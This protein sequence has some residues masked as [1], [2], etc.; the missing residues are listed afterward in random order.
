[1]LFPLSLESARKYR[2]NKQKQDKILEIILTE[3]CPEA[4]LKSVTYK[5]ISEVRNKYNALDS[6]VDERNYILDYLKDNTSESTTAFHVKGKPICKKAWVTI[7]GINFRRFDRID[8]DFRTGSELYVHGNSGLKRPTTKTS[9]CMAWLRFLVNAV[10]DHQP[11]TAKIHLPSCFTKVLLYKKMCEELNS[12]YHV[13][14]SQFYNIMDKEFGHVSIPKVCDIQMIGNRM[15]SK[16]SAKL[17]L[18]HSR[19]RRSPPVC[20]KFLGDVQCVRKSF[21]DSSALEEIA[22]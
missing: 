12:D 2:Q 9:E 10:G 13:S 21:R 7:H 19:V 18:S 20:G 8:Q 15:T 17:A 14:Q 6:I 5:D 3:C 16:L 11:D 22:Q 4:C 1:M